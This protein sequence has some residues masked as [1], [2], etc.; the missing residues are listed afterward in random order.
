[1]GRLVPSVRSRITCRCR[2]RFRTV[3]AG[4]DFGDAT[5]VMD[6]QASAV[7][8]TS[9]T[10]PIVRAENWLSA[11]EAAAA[12]GVSQRTVRRAIA[13]GD[14]PANKRSGAYRI[15]LPDLARFRQARR[16]AVPPANRPSLAPL[17]LFSVPDRG[18]AGSPALPRPRA[19]L[20]GREHELTVVR[21]LLLRPDVPLVTLT[22]PGG[23]GKTRLALDV[24]ADLREAFGNGVWF[25]ALAPLVDP[26]LVP[27]AIA[28]A[29]GVRE[30]GDRPLPQRLAAFLAPRPALLL[31]DNFEHLTAAAPFLADL[32][33]ACPGLTLLVTSRVVLHL[34]GEHRF[35]LSP[36]ALPDLGR[37]G[38]PGGIADAP[39]VRLFCVRARAVHPAFA[40]TDD[41]AAAVAAICVGLDGLPLAIELA[42]ARSSVLPPPAL[43][44]RLERR[45]PLLTGGPR[46][47]PQRLRTLRDAI[48]WSYDLLSENEQALFRRLAVFAGGA[49]LEAAA[50]VAGSGVDVLDGVSSLVASSLLHREVP[51]GAGPDAGAPRYLVLETLREFGLE[52]L[53]AA[54][55]TGETRRRHAA[56]F[57]ALS[58]RGYPHHFGPFAGI[59][60]RFR[61]L[62]A[63]QA[64][65]RAAFAFLADAGHAEAVLRMAG[66]LAIFWQHR[67]HLREGRQWLE[68]GL[69]HAPE[70]PTGPRGR[71]LAGLSLIRFVQGE[72]EQSES[73]ARAALAIGERIGDP[74]VTAHAFHRLGEAAHTQERWEEAEPLLQQAL[75][76]RR[77]LKARAEEGMALLHLSS[78]AFGMGD[79]ALSARRAEEALAGFRAIG[80]DSGAALALCRLAQ[81]ARDRRDDRGAAVTY[82]DAL[83]LWAGIRD[84]LSVVLAL[85]GL[86]ELASAHRSAH[87]AATLQGAIDALVEEAGAALPPSARGNYARATAAARAAVGEERSAALR[88]AGR[89]LTLDEAIAVAAEVRVPSGATSMMLTPREQDVLRLVAGARTDREIADALYVSPRT[90]NAHVASIL[91]KLGVTTRR[92]AAAQAREMGLLPEAGEA[93]PHT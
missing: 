4:P 15:A 45:L 31:L 1:M 44:A 65:M 48:A 55:E 82:R 39:A 12:L 37:T 89:R 79:H 7:W 81:L 13:R 83:R 32:L 80:H 91:G 18:T 8:T 23:V 72:I 66:A 70:A 34:S 78:V 14:L 59:A 77:A 69:D 17:R 29:L 41:N 67:A 85:A 22:G 87:A 90:V 6:K 35:P 74:G 33:D 10:E 56:Y 28:E 61:H 20:I 38:A 42:A 11:T 71:A 54:G 58:E 63:E 25:V 50:A 49:T 62:E 93:V 64:N 36:L 26:A 2:G 57:A 53:E 75:E 68:W 30:T 19:D 60:D 40:L 51:P 52:E 73:L 43:L 46:D 16:S 21:S 47:A 27:A 76:R 9:D 84:R 3:V 92:E 86:A 24:A 88:A 5:P